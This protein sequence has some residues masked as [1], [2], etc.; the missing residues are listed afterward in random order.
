MLNE[1]EKYRQ[2]DFMA[3]VVKPWDDLFKLLNKP[4]CIDPLLGMPIGTARGLVHAINHQ[5]DILKSEVVNGG[6]SDANL[7]AENAAAFRIRALSN[8]I[9]HVQHNPNRYF[10]KITGVVSEVQKTTRSSYCF[11]RNKIEYTFVEKEQS[12]EEGLT[13]DLMNDMHSAIKFWAH[14]RCIHVKHLKNWKENMPLSKP[15]NESLVFSALYD[16]EISLS[17]KSI[18]VQLMEEFCGR[19]IPLDAPIPSFQVVDSEPPHALI[20]F[21]RTYELPV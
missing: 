13:F 14:K 7:R 10:S 4:Y 17:Q 3:S 1:E 8:S 11:L 6:L 19:F 9:K 16:P 2:L 20:A 5:N 21:V 18:R 12:L 15:S